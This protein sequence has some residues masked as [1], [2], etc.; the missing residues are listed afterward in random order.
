MEDNLFSF[1]DFKG[2]ACFVVNKADDSSLKLFI[3]DNGLQYKNYK[4]DDV[5]H[6]VTPCYI[7]NDKDQLF[8][9]AENMIDSNK[10]NYEGNFEILKRQIQF[11]ESESASGNL[12]FYSIPEDTIRMSI[13]GDFK[14]HFD[15]NYSLVK[16]GLICGFADDGVWK[17]KFLKNVAL[18]DCTDTSGL[19]DGK[20]YSV[21]RMGDGCDV[22]EINVS[23]MTEEFKN[24]L[25]EPDHPD[26]NKELEFIL[27]KNGFEKIYQHDEI[28]EFIEALKSGKIE[29]HYLGLPETGIIRNQSKKDFIKS[30][31]EKVMPI[32]CI[33]YENLGLA[34]RFGQ[35]FKK[36]P[37]VFNVFDLG[38]KAGVADYEKILKV[39][40]G[41]N[42]SDQNDRNGKWALLRENKTK[43]SREVFL[44][45]Q[46]FNGS[47]AGEFLR[48][49]DEKI[50]S[51]ANGQSVD[52]VMRNFLKE[53]DDKSLE[54]LGL[55]NLKMDKN[56]NRKV[57]EKS[58]SR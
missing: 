4:F 34:G 56:E 30:P 13:A 27:K 8:E 53:I 14:E 41:L 16:N 32:D 55:S 39:H 20:L 23:D 6:D 1:D 58:K 44:V 10:K 37:Y 38:K 21:R 29:N 50:K 11:L 36:I 33:G 31:V 42:F 25:R 18:D 52:S 51:I 7:N 35:F 43:N 3:F 12:N 40:Y 26:Y 28:K 48:Q 54:M 2:V 57:N 22:D 17:G 49:F 19:E 47:S 45:K 24:I 9:S 5:F 15:I 46:D